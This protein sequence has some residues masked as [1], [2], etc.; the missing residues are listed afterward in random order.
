LLT[1]ASNGNLTL[2][3]IEECASEETKGG[4]EREED[5]EKDQVCA[6]GTD[7]VDETQD[8]HADHEVA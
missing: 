3:S 4:D 1:L 8:A 5:E 6:D 7:E 2:S